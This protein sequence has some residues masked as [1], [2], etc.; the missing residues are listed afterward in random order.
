MS[1]R[2]WFGL[3]FA[4]AGAWSCSKY[5]IPH[6]FRLELA[7]VILSSDPA[8]VTVRLLD[9]ERRLTTGQAEYPLTVRPEGLAKLGPQGTVTCL[10]SGDGT[11]ELTLGSNHRTV[12]LRCRLV[13]RVDASNVGRVELTKGA[14]K[15]NIVVYGKEGQVLD[16]VEL[17]LASKNTGVLVPKGAELLPKEVGTATVIARA[18]QV[19]KEFTV[20][21]VRKIDVEALPLEKNTKIFFSLEPGKYELKVTLSSPQR[22][23]AQWR[24]APYCN[25]ANTASEHVSVCVL[26]AKGGVAFDSPA[27]LMQGSTEISKDG[28]SLYEIP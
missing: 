11:V 16:G 1:F 2:S 20:D 12:P 9:A 7:D 6:D 18:G 19:K 3:V 27:Y 13:E 24:E 14:F 17:L 8:K 15:P 5:E 22:L 21:V 28:I 4:V 26:R 10:R 25:Y 23:T